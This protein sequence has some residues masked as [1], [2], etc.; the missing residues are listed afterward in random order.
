MPEDSLHL[1]E[2]NHTLEVLFGTDGHLEHN[3]VGAKDV[4]HLL[5]GLEEV[6][7]RAVHLVHVTDTGHIIL[8][9]LTPNGL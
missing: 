5:N 4:N 7:T 1:D 3:G 2:V 8:V 6:S 9:S